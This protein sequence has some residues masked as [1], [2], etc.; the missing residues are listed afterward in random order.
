MRRRAKPTK[1]KV[2]GKPARK[3]PRSD[4]TRVRDL[5]KRLA[6][7]LQRE[8]DASKRAAE[9]VGQLQTRDREMAEAQEQQTATSEIL[10]VISSSPTGYQSVF[11]TIVRRAGVVCGAID[12]ILWTV[13]GHELVVRAHHGPIPATIGARQ[14][15]H[16]SVA[17]G[18]VREARIVHVEDLTQADDFPVGR[19][20]AR[21]LGWRTTL[22]APLLREGVAI[23]ALL[24]RRSEVRPFTDRQIALL[25]TFADEAVIAI[26]NVRLFTELQASNRELRVALE[27]QTATSELLKVIGQSTFDLRPVF[28]TLAENATRLC[29]ARH[30]SIWRFDGQVLRVVAAQ[31]FSA[32]RRAF[33]ERTPIAP[34][35]GSGVARAALERRTIHIRDT[36]ADPEYTYGLQVAPART[37]L[38]IPMLRAEELLGVILVYRHEVLPFTDSHIALLETFADQAAIAIEN[39]RLLKELEG[40]N[41]DLTQALEQQTATSEILRVISGALTDVQPVFRAILERA[42]RLCGAELGHFWLYDG[43]GAFRLVEWLGSRPE[44]V[45]WLRSRRHR[46]GPPFFREAGPWEAGQIEDVGAT[47]PYRRGDE[48]WVRSVDDDGFRTLLN[49]PLVQDGRFIGALSIYRREVRRFSEPQV[50]LVKTFADQA[51]IAIENV[52]LFTELQQKN[53]ALTQAHAQVTEAL[54]QQTATSEILRVISS[55]PTDVQPVFDAIALSARRLCDATI[56]V[57]TRFDGELLHL[58]AH[59]HVRTEGVQAMLQAFP[60]RPSRTSTSS[61][62][63][64]DCAVVHVPDVLEDRDYSRSLA[65]GLQNRS[66][67]AVPMLRDGEPIGSIAVARLEPVPFTDAQ[68]ALLQT[69]ADQAV[70][71]IENVRLLTELQARTEDLTRSVGELRALGE[72]GQAIGSTLDLQTVLTTIVARAT[73]LAGADAGVIYEYDEQREIFEPRASEGLEE[74]I[75]QALVTT[76]IRRGQGV[77]GRLAEVMAPIPLPDLHA[78]SEQLPVRDALIGAGYRALLAVPLVREGHLIGALTS[79]RKTPGEF[80]AN[81][82]E[83]LQTFATQSALAIQNARLFREIEI[84]SRELE[85]ASQHKSEFLA[86]M[87]HELRTPLNAIIG[88]SDVLLQGMFGDMTEKQTEYL[89]DILAS[90]QHLLSLIN[91]ILDLSKIEAGRMDLELTDFHLPSAIDDALLLMRER[92]SRRGLTLER[93]VDERLGEV[94]A[95]QRKVKQ[96]LLNLLSNA[97][98][99]T[100]EGGRINVRAALVDGRV[101]ISVTDTGIGIA[102]ED[103]ETIFEEFRQV[104]TAEKKV[105]GTGLGLALSRKFIELHEGRIWVQSQVG[106]GS[107]FTFTIPPRR[108]E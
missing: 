90:G 83:L 8:A 16:G 99:F 32:E 61:R 33:L 24:I 29:E 21:R 1:A 86:S 39:A 53:E 79:F 44:H 62:A 85:V 28:E 12:A 55:S 45:E 56:G 97:V 13:E 47:E 19:D 48:V 107:T 46:F 9:A 4:D 69:F 64:L 67:L 60:M 25:Q 14:P 108:V 31:S 6:D 71:A 84:K 87:S 89:Q 88:F 93:H 80:P 82:V 10:R 98:K 7:A 11:D 37:L 17:G 38:A 66:T 63:V 105:E 106:V 41:H 15:T 27:Q 52:R 34:G 102:R 78:L 51:V 104:G 95:D 42:T 3:P 58:V 65:L 18:A 43:A 96:V 81:V 2:Q 30:A 70:I 68:I 57:I 54:E 50:N 49:V 40:R 94:R 35:R 92:A 59:E 73:Q 103:Q 76:P 20:I 74:E 75:V 72:V 101:E 22:S 5:E 100:P 91:D 26:E 77:T 36:L 23:G